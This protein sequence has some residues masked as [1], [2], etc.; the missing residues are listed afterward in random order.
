M[1]YV[2]FSVPIVG[3]LYRYSTNKITGSTK[4]SQFYLG[5]AMA[6]GGHVIGILMTKFLMNGAGIDEHL[7][8]IIA[9][10]GGIH[11]GILF[12]VGFFLLMQRR[13]GNSR[14]KVNT[15]AQTVGY[16]LHFSRR[17]QRAAWQPL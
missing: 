11:A 14:I 5:L 9:L 15:S 1:P 12:F 2:A 16:T 17:R 8:Y 7:Y 10:A 6:F 4:S 3:T 13:F